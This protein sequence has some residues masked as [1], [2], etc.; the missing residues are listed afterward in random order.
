[1]TTKIKAKPV[2]SLVDFCRSAPLTTSGA[3]HVPYLVKGQPHVVK[4]RG[5]VLAGMFVAMIC[6]MC[7]EPC[8]NLHSHPDRPGVMCEKCL[9]LYAEPVT[10]EDD[11]ASPAK[12]A[13]KKRARA[14][15][16]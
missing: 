7:G 5:Q 16:R 4:L 9:A 6:P 13:P 2:I 14:G 12:S 1:M 8:E 11:T 3:I 10:V 15:V